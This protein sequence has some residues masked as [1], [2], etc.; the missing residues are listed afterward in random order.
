M[1]DITYLGH[2]SFKLRGKS[3]AVVTDPFDPKFVGLK[4][5]PPQ[6][7]IVTISHGHPDHNQF[8][9]V[10]DV[11]KVISGPGEY[12]VL[13]VSIIGVGSFHDEKQGQL[14]GRNTIYVYEI[15]GLR[16]CHLGDLG[17]VITDEAA[18]QLGAID[19]LMIP[20]G[21]EFT[22]GPKEA[23]TTIGKID[24]YFVIPMHYQTPGLNQ[25]N[26]AKLSPLADFLSECR[27]TVENMLKFTVR[28][29]EISED[30]GAKV[31][32]LNTP[33]QTAPKIVH[34]Q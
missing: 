25:D 21:G 5:F 33:L 28:K 32:V 26:F 22:I 7:D 30:S 11:K 2:S 23:I 3:A 15:D 34:S 1:M 20:T 4:F 9:L 18:A 16:L 10:K 12:E 6:A 31:I 13:G 19:I 29:E 14:R 17:Q 27:L 24:P 8:N